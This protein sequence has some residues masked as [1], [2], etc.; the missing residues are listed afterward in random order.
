M[1]KYAKIHTAFKA[2]RKNAT[3]QNRTKIMLAVL[4]ACETPDDHEIAH[5]LTMEIIN[6]A[7]GA[8]DIHKS[9]MAASRTVGVDVTT[10]GGGNT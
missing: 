1:K 4:N 8:S 3:S 9:L 6:S 7:N 5:S 2:F 10:L